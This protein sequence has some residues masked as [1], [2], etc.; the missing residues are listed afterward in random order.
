MNRT[1]DLPYR[2]SL[3]HVVS[4]T[5]MAKELEGLRKAKKELLEALKIQMEPERKDRVA[6]ARR[7]I[8]KYE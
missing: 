4:V 7:T 2:P 8:R 1:L 5:D 6:V 3:L